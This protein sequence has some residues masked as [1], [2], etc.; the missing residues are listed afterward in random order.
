MTVIPIRAA[1][2]DGKLGSESLP[3]CNS[4]IANTRDAIHLIRQQNAVP[5]NRAHR[6]EAVVNPQSDR[7]AFAPPQSRRGHR[8][9]DR[10]GGLHSSRERHWR[11]ADCQIKL[12]PP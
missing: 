6:S 9:I 2:L 7:R 11:V 1:L 4:R 3:R 12:C 8:A 10:R 5:M